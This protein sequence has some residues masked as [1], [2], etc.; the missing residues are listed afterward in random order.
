MPYWLADPAPWPGN[1]MTNFGVI[2]EGTLTLGHKPEA[3]PVPLMI[4]LSALGLASAICTCVYAV[5]RLRGAAWR[6]FA[7]SPGTGRFAALTIPFLLGCLPVLALRA[8]AFGIFDR[9]FIPHLFV[10]IALALALCARLTTNLNW[11]GL[12]WAGLTSSL[13]LALYAIATTHD[14]FADARAKLQAAQQVLRA[15]NNRTSV[16]G[17]FEF[18]LWTQAEIAGHVNNN[19]LTFPKDAY[20]QVDDCNGPDEVLAW[21]RDLAPALQARYVVTLTPFADM[22]NAFEPV[23]YWRWLPLSKNYVYV[24]SP[25]PQDTPLTCKPDTEN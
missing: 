18:D 10:A 8:P 24:E 22:K 20:H 25:A 2:M 3:L 1:I 21:W 6:Q 11:T 13:V 4:L 5:G 15:G 7:T 17:G 16:I 9:Y 14:Y 12:N 19:L 23:E